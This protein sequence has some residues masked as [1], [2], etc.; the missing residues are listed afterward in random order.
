M[1]KFI[2]ESL[3]SELQSDVREILLQCNH[4]KN[5]PEEK[6]CQSPGPGQWSMAQVLE[7]M[8]IYARYYIRAIEDAIHLNQKK[9]SPHFTSGWLGQYFTNLMKP[10]DSGKLKSTMSSPKN[11]RPG[12]S[13]EGKAMLDEF[14]S[15]QHHFINLLEISR[16]TNLKAIRVPTSLS[17]WIRLSLGDTFRFTIAHQQRH[18]LQ[19]NRI[20]SKTE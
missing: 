9:S 15:H 5:L 10:S 18:M 7:H 17:K 20:L 11:A 16:R 3:I 19:I 2:S 12:N 1:K 6:L 13:A 14:L 4:L 8:N